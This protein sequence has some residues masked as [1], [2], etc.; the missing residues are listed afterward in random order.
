MPPMVL[1]DRAAR[2][3]RRFLAAAA[4][5][6][7]AAACATAHVPAGG[8]WQEETPAPVPL[9]DARSAVLRALRARPLPAEAEPALVFRARGG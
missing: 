4:L 3:R 7:V 9:A 8:T 6:P 2:G 1:P 5:A